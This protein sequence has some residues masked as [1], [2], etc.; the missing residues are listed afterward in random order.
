MQIFTLQQWQVG[1]TIV[2]ERWLKLT[3]TFFERPGLDCAVQH[4]DFKALANKA[5]LLQVGTLL[6]EKGRQAT[7]EKKDQSETSKLL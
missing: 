1:S 4:E 3:E 7:S 5:V 2:A 6:K